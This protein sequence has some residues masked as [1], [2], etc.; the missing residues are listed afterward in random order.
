LNNGNIDNHPVE[1]DVEKEAIE[2]RL[3]E[4]FKA[5]KLSEVY[6]N[7]VNDDYGKVKIAR[8]RLDFA[9]HELLDIIKEA[10]NKGVRLKD[11][12]MV[13]KFLYDDS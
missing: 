11:N 2:K 9:R 5:Y 13:K 1:P 10:N 12:E 7:N 3:E 4:A 8:L 6:L